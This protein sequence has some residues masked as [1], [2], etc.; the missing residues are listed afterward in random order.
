M[1]DDTRLWHVTITVGGAPHESTA[2]CDALQ[3]L[4]DERPFLHDLRYATTTAEISY[5]EQA[6]GMLDAASLALR[7]WREHRDTAGLP[8]WEVVGLEVLE[9]QTFQRRA[10][11]STPALVG[12]ADARPRQL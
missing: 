4:A 2:V 11:S 7:V 1:N 5:W 9:R 8:Q 10:A 3:R 12:L 6:D